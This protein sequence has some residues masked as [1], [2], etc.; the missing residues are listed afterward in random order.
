MTVCQ[1]GAGC[2]PQLRDGMKS[3]LN[4]VGLLSPQISSQ[5]PELQTQMPAIPYSQPGKAPAPS[6]VIHLWARPGEMRRLYKG[7]ECKP[8]KPPAPL[9]APPQPSASPF[10]THHHSQC[11]RA[12]SDHEAIFRNPVRERVLNNQP[13]YFCA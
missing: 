13:R 6:G 8:G 4:A 9:W 7:G 3:V 10:K 12:T 11:S 5:S 1:P 2:W